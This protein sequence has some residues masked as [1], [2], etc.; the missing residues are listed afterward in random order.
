MSTPGIHVAVHTDEALLFTGAWMDFTHTSMRRCLVDDSKRPGSCGGQCLRWCTWEF[1]HPHQTHAL[2]QNPLCPLSLI[3]TWTRRAVFA[4]EGCTVAST[5]D[6]YHA[7]PHEKLDLLAVQMYASGHGVVDFTPSHLAKLS[8]RLALGLD[9]VSQSYMRRLWQWGDR[10]WYDPA[11]F[12]L[13]LQGTR[14]DAGR[15]SDCS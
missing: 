7:N 5:W 13:E 15:F 8:D 11:F 10:V 6:R 2:L 14:C 3:G 1:T 4:Q 12:M 9:G